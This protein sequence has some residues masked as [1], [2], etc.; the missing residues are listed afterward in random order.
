[1]RGQLETDNIS[2]TEFLIFQLLHSS[3]LNFGLFALFCRVHLPDP[4]VEPEKT[5]HNYIGI[6][7]VSYDG[8]LNCT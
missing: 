6:K 1:M 8:Q 3:H 7:P 5:T 2:D 4:A